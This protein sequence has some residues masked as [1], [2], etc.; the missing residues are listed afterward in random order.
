MVP[1]EDKTVRWTFSGDRL[2]EMKALLPE[3]ALKMMGL[4]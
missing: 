3:Y 4:W 2:A 1:E